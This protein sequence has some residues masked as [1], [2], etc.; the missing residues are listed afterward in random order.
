MK[1]ILYDSKN[2]IKLRKYSCTRIRKIKIKGQNLVKLAK[3]K[4]LTYV[5]KQEFAY[6]CFPSFYIKLNT[7]E[8][9]KQNHTIPFGRCETIFSGSFLAK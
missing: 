6:L 1:N 5:S 4:N 8:V 2:N 3:R 7:F 9:Y